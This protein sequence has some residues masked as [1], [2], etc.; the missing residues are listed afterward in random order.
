[1]S[2]RRTARRIP[3]LPCRLALAAIGGFAATAAAAQAPLSPPEP[4]LSRITRVTLH[5]GAAVVERTAKVPAGAREVQLSCLPEGFD[6]ASLRLDADA[7][8][9][10]GPVTLASVPRAQAPECQ[11]SE[12]DARIRGLEDRLAAVQAESLGHE[13]VLGHLRAGA[14]K[15]AASAEGGDGG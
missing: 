7:P 10:L 15:G 8:I 4:Q 12:L 14:G 13:L 3:G 6:P 9:T 5:P 11:R 1:M 2:H